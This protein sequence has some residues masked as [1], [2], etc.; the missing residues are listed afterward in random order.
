MNLGKLP[1][2]FLAELLAKAER[3][4]CVLVGPRVGED[5]AVI[6]FGDRC[7]VVKTDP[8][9][10][11]A[12]RLGWYAVHVNANDIAVMGADPRWFLMT[13]L[14]PPSATESD[15]TSIFDQVLAAGRDLGVTLVGGHTEVTTGIDRPLLIGCM[16]GETTRDRIITSG[17]ARPGDDVV[18]TSGIAIEG[19]SVLAREAADDLRARGVAESTIIE[20]RDYLDAPG[21]SVVSAAR[22]AACAARVTSLHDPTEGGLAAGLW[23]VAQASGVGME[24]EAA[25][26]PVLPACRVLCDTLGLDPLRLIASG[27]LLITVPHE[28]TSALVDA[29]SDGGIK[30]TRIGRVVPATDGLQ[31]IDDDGAY[32]LVVSEQ[33]EVARY[34]AERDRS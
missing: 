9:T 2:P 15:V 28:E 10:F 23:E 20:A 34:F 21:I 19:A 30:A 3:D 24:I 7:L 8:I 6:D 32:A 33:D 1:Y 11:T 27:C 4:P 17:G 29:L 16:L 5:A 31:L 18:I 14:L 12:D 22:I 25:A 26:I 13:L